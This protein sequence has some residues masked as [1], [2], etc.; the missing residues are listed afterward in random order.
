MYCWK[1][2][3]KLYD[4]ANYCFSCG[5]KTEL[6]N[7]DDE[8]E[9]VTQTTIVMPSPS[10]FNKPNKVIPKLNRTSINSDN[11]SQEKRDIK[12]ARKPF[13][14]FPKPKLLSYIF[15][16]ILIP[17]LLIL[18]AIY[19]LNKDDTYRKESIRH[20][21]G[22]P[23]FYGVLFLLFGIAALIIIW[24][25]YFWGYKRHKLSVKN[26]TEYAALRER[27]IKED[28]ERYKKQQAERERQLAMTPACP[29]CGKKDITRI[30]T[31]SRS[32]SIAM[33]GLASSKI[34][35]QYQCNNCKHMW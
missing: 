11:A 21:N 14:G 13:P 12:A 3:K 31:T 18:F 30:S 28:H 17:G 16:T 9:I 7:Q 32:L 33:V 8:K 26:P 19:N 4:N 27:E 29:I 35:K 2:G 23:R 15:S 25:L 34:G 20:G 22:D 6:P 1:C 10:E 24:K 5:T